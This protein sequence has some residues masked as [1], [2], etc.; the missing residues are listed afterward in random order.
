MGIY[1]TAKRQMIIQPRVLGRTEVITRELTLISG[2][3]G[4]V[5]RAQYATEEEAPTDSP[6]TSPGKQHLK[7]W[8]KS[9]LEMTFDDPEQ[10]PPYWVGTNNVILRTPF[11]GVEIKGAA[12]VNSPTVMV[13][14]SGRKSEVAAVS[15]FI[16]SDRRAL[17]REL[18]PG[19]EIDSNHRW[20]IITLETELA[21]DD[22]RR[23]WLKA[24]LNQ[25]VNVLRPRLR[26]WYSETA[27]Q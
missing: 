22:D 17:L 4:D 19:T 11:R 5:V 25:Y 24:T 27:R 14:L 8:W 10:E 18:P 20:P 3:S 9:V 6:Q 16:R 23:A 1:E 2:L 12:L 7:E 15:D 21:G 26:K 13:F